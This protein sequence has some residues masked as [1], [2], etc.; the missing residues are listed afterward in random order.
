[1]QIESAAGAPACAPGLVEA[2]VCHAAPRLRIL[3]ISA[4]TSTP[5]IGM[6]SIADTLAREG[7]EVRILHTQI[8]A[9]VEPGF[10]AGRVAAEG[11][12]DIA[13]IAIHWAHQALESIEIA[14]AIRAASP[15]IFIVAGG[16]TASAF[17]G[18][19]LETTPAI[20]V[21]VRGEAEG[22][23]RQLVAELA[24]ARLAGD[25]PRFETVPNLVW[26]GE[27]RN[28][29]RTLEI[30]RER[31]GFRGPLRRPEFDTGSGR[32]L[33]DG[34]R[35]NAMDY[36][37][38]DHELAAIRYARPD[39]LLH[40]DAV[41]SLRIMAARL[42][43]PVF[44]LPT[45]RGCPVECAFC[46]GGRSCHAA[47]GAR[48]K[49]EFRPLESVLDDLRS[50]AAAGFR[51]FY[52]C[53]D[54]V[55]NGRYFFELFERMKAEGLA[56]KFALGFGSWGL[57]S[58]AFLEAVR[59][60]FENAFFEISPESSNEEI[61]KRVRGFSFR[62]RDFEEALKLA[63]DSGIGVEVYFTFPLPGDNEDTMRATRSWAH[64]LARRHSDRIQ[65]NVVALS[66][67]PQAPLAV[68]PEAFGVSI[69]V[70]TFADYLEAQRSDRL[71]YPVAGRPP[72]FQNHLYHRPAR[73]MPE[74]VDLAGL[75][76]ITD[77]VLWLRRP[78]LLHAACDA[79]GGAY[80]F[81]CF[82]ERALAPV[83]SELKAERDRTG[84]L[85]ISDGEA[86]RR[87]VRA[88]AAA[89]ERELGDVVP[90]LA[91]VAREAWAREDLLSRRFAQQEA[92]A[93]RSWLNWA[94]DGG[95]TNVGP[96]ERPRSR[97][98]GE[99][100]LVQAPPYEAD[101][102]LGAEAL[103]AAADNPENPRNIR[104]LLSVDDGRDEWL[105]ELTPAVESALALADGTLTGEEIA[106][107]LAE[108][109][110]DGA[111][112]VAD[113]VECGAFAAR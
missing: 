86:A 20:D 96:S 74:S 7:H 50:A 45:S 21:V 60:T 19:I 84:S 52:V 46:G 4:V 88:L 53:H 6:Y 12:F 11:A 87:G 105:L 17:A 40:R 10:D 44:L 32:D 47:L 85:R 37:A 91:D 27:R 2:A 111:Q 70:R 43:A 83:L 59:D 39:L 57:P 24:R 98:T 95:D 49:A 31:P 104:V 34:I 103:R 89:V 108:G 62:N 92:S 41:L 109:G 80:Q 30:L 102:R 3:L 93:A 113:L 22:P 56:R 71:S 14:Q 72:W 68:D 106:A 26:R 100:L 25:A 107:V 15:R 112:T 29:K 110:Q 1:M 76:A 9:T 35:A 79:L 36:V 8:A 67:D 38:R 42:P 58:H 63:D 13:G 23:M 94:V 48:S 16:L 97:A 18:E 64:E 5:P 54:P 33:A 78:L 73:L 51:S 99:V 65:M 55:P 82:L 61:R 66:T 101:P 81:E 90:G 69:T 77:Y 75:A 28:G